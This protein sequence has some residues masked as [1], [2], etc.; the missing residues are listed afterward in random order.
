MTIK[1]RLSE[2]QVLDVLAAERGTSFDRAPGGD[3]IFLKQR[4]PLDIPSELE[5]C[6]R[7]YQQEQYSHAVQRAMTIIKVQP[8]NLDAALL[9][10]NC[11]FKL[12]NYNKSIKA[13]KIAL[14]VDPTHKSAYEL[15]ITAL[16]RFGRPKEASLVLEE[17][18]A[19]D[20]RD[21]P[22]WSHY[23]RLLYQTGQ[24]EKLITQFKESPAS[25]KKDLEA[26][27][28]VAM[29]LERSHRYREALPLYRYVAKREPSNAVAVECARRVAT[30]LN[31]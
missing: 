29:S 12:G 10:G 8:K 3:W 1:A 13:L 25:V 23:C 26:I 16:E 15:L 4:P 18:I 19:L 6:N 22:R 9:L 27:L 28:S 5:S 20:N 14:R 21:V 30:Q 2:E 24:Y 7:L 17:L 11:H 31:Q